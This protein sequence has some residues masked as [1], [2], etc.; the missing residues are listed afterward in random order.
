[1]AGMVFKHFRKSIL[2][3]NCLFAFRLIFVYRSYLK[4][5][6][7]KKQTINDDHQ[8]LVGRSDLSASSKITWYI[9]PREFIY[10]HI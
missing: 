5:K 2:G 6:K 10:I 4:Q 1:M 9:Y 3:E 8:V 7:K